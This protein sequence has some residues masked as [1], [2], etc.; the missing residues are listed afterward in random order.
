M[1]AHQ[2][3][4]IA[5]PAT[6]EHKSRERPPT[7]STSSLPA[8]SKHKK[9][10]DES[11]ADQP[12]E[13]DDFDISASTSTSSAS[14]EERGAGARTQAC[15][16]CGV[17]KIGKML[18]C[19]KCKDAFYC[20]SRCQQAAWRRSHKNSCG[21]PKPSEHVSAADDDDELI[22][23][24][25]SLKS[26]ISRSMFSERAELLAE[27]TLVPANETADML[28]QRL[29]ALFMPEIQS[30]TALEK[31]WL[32]RFNDEAHR[33][34]TEH[35][36]A[37]NEYSDLQKF[38]GELYQSVRDNAP[39]EAR[40]LLVRQC[41]EIDGLNEALR[42]AHAEIKELKQAAG[43]MPDC[44]GAAAPK[45]TP[46]LAESDESDDTDNATADL[47][48]GASAPDTPAVKAAE[49]RGLRWAKKVG[50][51]NMFVCGTC[52]S[53]QPI[54]SSRVEH[55]S[56]CSTKDAAEKAVTKIVGSESAE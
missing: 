37:V 44:A 51:E 32:M 4:T 1:S 45:Q 54:R 33:L 30:F 43:N 19:S 6:A 5:S 8:A 35:A 18:R 14:G 15:E 23:A 34:R 22:R 16:F 21:K 10:S 13:A 48:A 40:R 31:V 2:S 3:A 20:D 27:E 38:V 53:G 52:V 50:K 26:P 36:K 11:S 29:Q 46:Q 17:Y 7:Q 9:E 12:S 49:S 24:F 56:S 25:K 41:N 47:G 28:K 39:D 42:R 55:Q